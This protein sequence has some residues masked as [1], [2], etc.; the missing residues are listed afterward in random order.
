MI[1]EIIILVALGYLLGSVPAGLIAGYLWLRRDIRHLGSGKTGS[2]NVLRTAGKSAAVFVLLIDM[3]KGAVPGLI[4]MYVLDNPWAGAAGA[5][6]AVTGHVWPIF[7]G[8]RGGRGV[9]TTWGG[10]FGLAPLLSLVFLLIALLILIPSRIVSLM[11]VLGTPLSAAV[12]VGAWLMGAVPLPTALYAV[13]VVVLVEYQ[14][15]PNIKRL[16]AGTEPRI[17]QGGDRP[18]TG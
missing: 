1:P 4:G 12:V 10:I 14:H 17:G 7:A 16:F 8:F 6:A 2:T 5:A 11:S 18:A 15:L 3:A 13:F 9:A